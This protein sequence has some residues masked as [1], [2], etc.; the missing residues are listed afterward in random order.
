MAAF[1]VWAAL[2]ALT[3]IAA[4]N[5]YPSR[6][7]L[8][9]TAP[10]LLWALAIFY[11]LFGLLAVFRPGTP[12]SVAPAFSRPVPI[13]V[14]GLMI[15]IVGAALFRAGGHTTLP[16]VMKTL[17][18]LAFV[19]GGVL[20][21]LPGVALIVLEWWSELSNAW[22]RVMG[23]LSLLLSV[24]FLG[25]AGYFNYAGDPADLPPARTAP[26]GGRTQPE[27]PEPP[28]SEPQTGADAADGEAA[29]ATEAT[30]ATETIES[31][32][33]GAP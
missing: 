12:R 9:R 32:E 6:E 31:T 33:G 22:L 2:A 4:A 29:T 5:L 16:L 1:V 11:F 24:L 17:G 19:E 14:A 28:E 3:A 18:F 20:L 10:W 23:A 27:N 15:M 25:A 26:P 8:E 7:F 13:R 30:E 21:L